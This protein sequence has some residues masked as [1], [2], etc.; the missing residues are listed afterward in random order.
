MVAFVVHTLALVASVMVLYWS[1]SYRGGFAWESTNKNL[2]FNLHPV[3][4]LIGLI[5]LGG[6]AIISYKWLRNEKQKK[7]KIHLVLHAIALILGIWGIC[8]AFKNHNESHIPNLYSLHSWIGIGVIVLYAFQW[9][10]SFIVFFFP[11]GSST[12]RSNLLPWHAFLGLFV[13][14]LAVGN[15]ALGFLEKLT[16]MENSGL[17]KFG[18]EAFLVNFM[19]IVTILFGTFVILTVSAKPADPSSDEYNYTYSAI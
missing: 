2:I 18:S 7:K 6:E 17:D 3:L 15:S 14:V 10:Y 4:M 11:R 12:L 9:H 5:I 13:Y 19:A 8:A 1:I 16:F